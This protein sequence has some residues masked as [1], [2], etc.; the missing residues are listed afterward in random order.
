MWQKL[1]R[2]KLRPRT[3]FLIILACTLGLLVFLVAGTAYSLYTIAKQGDLLKTQQELLVQAQIKLSELQKQN[4][5]MAFEIL[6]QTQTL[7]EETLTLHEQFSTE[8]T[9]RLAAQEAA[10]RVSLS[11]IVKEWRP[12]IASVQCRFEKGSQRG[13]GTLIKDAGKLYILT[14]NH[15]VSSNR[16]SPY[17]CVI[18]FPGRTT[19]VIAIT[20]NTITV[21]SSKVDVATI[22]LD[23]P[24]DSIA[25]LSEKYLTSGA[26]GFSV[27]RETPALGEQIIILGYPAIGGGEDIT[28]TDG[29]VAGFDGNYFV[30]SAK[31]ERGNS[32]GAAIHQGR[33][34]YLGI[35]TFVQSGQIESLA[36]ILKATSIFD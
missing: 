16:L 1:R 6:G 7:K 19:Q 36:R 23:K 18:Q 27:C 12:L 9:K 33:D 24:N 26:P 32:G 11:N 22:L 8:Q 20:A 29:I 3:I 13:S 4:S 34:C 30:T 5:E 25:E 31:V 21:D 15:V 2:L 17:E 10:D 35:P 14:N 28:A